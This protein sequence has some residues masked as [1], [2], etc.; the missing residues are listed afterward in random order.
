MGAAG[1]WA[2]CSRRVAEVAEPAAGGLGIEDFRVIELAEEAAVALGDIHVEIEHGGAGGAAV[3]LG[4]GGPL[5]IDAAGVLA[6]FAGLE[7]EGDGEERGAAEIARELEA[8]DEIAKE[9]LLML[10][11]VE[12]EGLAGAD[13]IGEWGGAADAA[14]KR[15]HV[16]GVREEGLAAFLR[17]NLGIGG[18][19][20]DDVVLAGEAMEQDAVC[21]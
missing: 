18:D 8:A 20:D 21:R 19:A 16:G 11:G 1:F 9:I 6:E 17:A 12:D 4:I 15:H 7:I 5:E 10:G 14:A 3:G 2:I 13:L